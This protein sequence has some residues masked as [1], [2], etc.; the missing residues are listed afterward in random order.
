MSSKFNW[1]R[2]L[3]KKLNLFHDA[4]KTSY[5]SSLKQK[6]RNMK[7]SFYFF[8]MLLAV[9]SCS[10]EDETH[11]SNYVNVLS[12]THTDC[13]ETKSITVDDEEMYVIS[14][15]DSDTYIVEHLNVYFNCCLDEGIEM[16]CY[17]NQDTIFYTDREKVIGICDCICPYNTSVEI[18]GICEGSTYPVY[19][20]KEGLKIGVAE[21]TFRNG[22]RETIKVADL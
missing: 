3:S 6:I 2:E 19:F 9:Y 7:Q 22:M 15:T 18:E 12:A 21:V 1:L 8:I 17:M 5:C 13:I 14:A 4:T 10:N 16:S 20:Q 11:S